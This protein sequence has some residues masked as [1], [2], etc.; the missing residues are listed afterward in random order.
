MNKLKIILRFNKVFILLCLFLFLYVFV[1]TKL[2]SY[3]SKY[4]L[5]ENRLVGKIIH[6]SINGNALKMDVKGKEVVKVTYYIK[7]KEEKEWLEKN[8]VLG[9]SVS[10]E[11]EF[12]EPKH[13]TIPN[14]FDYKKYLYQ[15]KIFFTFTPE[16]YAFTKQN[17]FLYKIKDSLLKKIYKEENNA[18]LLLFL[19]GDKSLISSEDYNAFKLNG[20][21]HLLAISGMHIGLL[22][23]GL[24]LLLGALSKNKRFVIIMFVLFFFAFLTG[25][26]PSVLR[27]IL[28]Y[29]LIH[30]NHSFKWGLCSLQVL[31]LVAFFLIIVNPFVIYDYGFL[32][33]IIITGGIIYY[34]EQIKGSYFKQ[35][36]KLS[37]ITFLFSLPITASINYEINLMSIVANMIFVPLVSFFVY[38]LSI[39]SLLWM[40]PLWRITIYCFTLLNTFFEKIKLMLVISKM[41]FLLIVAFLIVLLLMKKKRKLSG[42]LIIILL[43]NKCYSLNRDYLLNFLDVGQGDALLIISPYQREVILIDTGGKMSYQ[44]EKWEESSKS[45]FLSDNVLLFLKSLGVD[46]ITFLIL[47]H[48]DF[49]HMGEAQHIVHHFKVE[50]VIF[51]CGMFNKLEKELISTLDRKKI[52]Y[53]SCLKE[54]SIGKDKLHFLNNVDYGNEND[55]SSVV[56]TELNNYKF[57]FMGDASVKVERY[58]MEKYKLQDIFLLKVGHHGSKTSSDKEFIDE[59]NP[60]YSIISVG[61]N[62]RYG[63]PNKEVLDNLEDTKIYRTDQDG[64]I[65]FK[66]KKDKLQ[67][68]TCSPLKGE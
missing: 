58:L 63:H 67:I 12:K 26:S 51:N 61:K 47:T 17:N 32:Y 53:G 24:N 18:Y 16:S 42:L 33:S 55:N 29:F 36:F 1:C 4:T 8:V 14:T 41:P 9:S 60:K 45:Y 57:L 2:I 20:T 43:L 22:I 6:Y 13:N 59:I 25:F 50:Q 27:V 19:L 28:F 30:L 11:G 3:E 40:S 62:N 54:L 68:K 31:F 56:Y 37:V 38:P 10:L 48:G 23:Q 44:K 49:D 64:S 65:M 39:F 35:L 66:I 46:K 21:A 52:T 34:S 5:D 15:H 7:D